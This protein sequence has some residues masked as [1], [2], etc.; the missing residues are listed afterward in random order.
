M[1]EKGALEQARANLARMKSVCRNECPQ[2]G[3]LSASIEEQA[4]KAVA[5]TAPAPAANGAAPANETQ[6]P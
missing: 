4:R 1:V 3:A 5:K 6:Q 2:I